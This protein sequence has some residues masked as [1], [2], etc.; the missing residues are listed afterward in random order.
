MNPNNDGEATSNYR[1]T[2]ETI[3]GISL[4][5][6]SDPDIEMRSKS[7]SP[8]KEDH[9][10]GTRREEN[11][12]TRSWK[13]RL[14]HIYQKEGLLIEVSIAILLAKIYPRLGAELL[15]PELTAHWIAVVIIFCKFE[16]VTV[17][18]FEINA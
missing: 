16:S 6:N 1:S 5:V 3:D 7:L 18:Q 8:R 13:E 12:E 4:G 9:Q 2:K 11:E 10:G 17:F 15:Y 14:A